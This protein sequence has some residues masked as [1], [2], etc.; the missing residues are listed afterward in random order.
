MQGY[1][2]KRIRPLSIELNEDPGTIRHAEELFYALTD[3]LNRKLK[4]HLMLLKG[5][6]YGKTSGGLKAAVDGDFW[7]VSELHGSVPDGFNFV[8]QRV[9]IASRE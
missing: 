3:A 7:E 2:K 9:E 1:F 4:S 8:L 5:T 6:K